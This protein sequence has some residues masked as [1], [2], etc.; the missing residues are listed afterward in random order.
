MSTD[1]SV[2]IFLV[3]YNHEKYISDCISSILN[4]SYKNFELIIVDNSSQDATL[5]IIKSFSD[6][7][8]RF[9]S[10]ENRGPSAAFN[11]AMKLAQ[12]E[13]W[14]FIS[15]DDICLPDRLKQQI[16]FAKQLDHRSLIFS[17]ATSIDQ[18]C[19]V[20]ENIDKRFSTRNKDLKKLPYEFLK[21]GNFLCAPSLLSHRAAFRNELFDENLIQLQDF[22]MWL[23]LSPHASFHVID[24]PLV[25]YRT[26]EANLSS[27]D[28][29]N[30]AAAQFENFLIWQRFLRTCNLHQLREL[31]ADFAPDESK[32]VIRSR[33]LFIY[34]L[35]KD[36]DAPELRL[37]AHLA[38]TGFGE[39]L[40]S[41]EVNPI[42]EWMSLKTR[43][44]FSG[45]QSA[46]KLLK[47]LRSKL[48]R[49]LF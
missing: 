19:Q 26:H 6:Q 46:K 1:P 49:R 28:P 37:L 34:Q 35:L 29:D 21:A 42:N 5:S 11:F 30:I 41:S 32:N 16:H 39:D 38:R 7:R 17:Q 3:T 31:F 25:Q 13:Y 22:D 48:R 12:F 9:F 18:S 14:S 36:S 24:T 20:L 23:R 4:Q 43:A 44:V 33:D 2:S 27:N 8:I 47:M 10:H 40:V 15:G 45:E